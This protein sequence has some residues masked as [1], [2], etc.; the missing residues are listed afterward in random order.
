MSLKILN[1]MRDMLSWEDLIMLLKEHIALMESG[2]P[3]GKDFL[4]KTCILVA[5]KHNK[6]IE[7][8]ESNSTDL[9]VN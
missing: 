2:A 9:E 5:A 4:A 8:D 6:E 7:D 1:L 3:N